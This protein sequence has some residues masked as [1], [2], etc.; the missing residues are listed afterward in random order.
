MMMMEAGTTHH[1][2]SFDKVHL[3]RQTLLGGIVSGTVNLVVVIVEARN[4]ST[5]ELCDFS[6]RAADA[7]A[8]I[9]NLHAFLDVHAV[10]K[11]VLV[12]SYG[13]AKRFTSREATKMK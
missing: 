7:T 6:S 12:A 8:N 3:F 4:L 2:V 10:G 11:V 9:E 1:K 13:L 5:G